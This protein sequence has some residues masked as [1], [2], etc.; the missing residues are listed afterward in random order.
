M[1]RSQKDTALIL[2]ELEWHKVQLNS[3]QQTISRMVEELKQKQGFIEMLIEQV[4]ERDEKLILMLDPQKYNQF[5]LHNRPRVGA[6]ELTEQEKK[7]FEERKIKVQKD[8]AQL[9]SMGIL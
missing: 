4:R 2:Q 9:K 1:F 8:V 3:C 6:V 5:K 7:E